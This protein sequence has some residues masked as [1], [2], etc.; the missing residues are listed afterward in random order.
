M[1]FRRK[2]D[3]L[4]LTAPAGEAADEIVKADEREQAGERA[5]QRGRVED[6]HAGRQRIDDDERDKEPA[7]AIRKWSARMPAAAARL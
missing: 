5:P 3:A 6:E 1:K 7:C 2:I 4:V